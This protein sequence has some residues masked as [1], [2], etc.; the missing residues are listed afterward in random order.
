MK[1]ISIIPVYNE[2]ERILDVLSACESEIDIF[3]IVN[4]GSS[5]GSMDI[6][7]TWKADKNNVHIIN[8]EKNRGMSW[9]V[10]EGFRFVEN[11][12]DNLCIS[13]QDIII[14]IDGDDQHNVQNINEI[15][16]YI[17]QNDIDYLITR[18]K[19]NGYPFIKVI[20]NKLMSFFL[21][22][23]TFKRF[24][25]VECG[26]RFVKVKLLSELLLYT[27]GCRYSWAQEMAAICIRSG[28]KLDNEWMIETKHYRKRGATFGDAFINCFFS[29][30]LL[31]INILMKIKSAG[32][33]KV[34]RK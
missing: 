10:K 11:N 5:D 23:V 16:N 8:G 20:G 32:H 29:S 18:R 28:F 24:H 33:L 27:I 26:Y 13:D 14:Q 34:E 9:A 1:K 30:V 4:D 25:D 22:I 15:I 2:E 12:K 6:I 17:V 31:H 3:V 21:S 19:L 7:N